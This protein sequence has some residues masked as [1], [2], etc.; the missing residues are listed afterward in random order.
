MKY[1]NIKRRL[2]T[3]SSVVGVT[4]LVLLIVLYSII[5]WHDSATKE[6]ETLQTQLAAVTNERQTLEG[7][8]H[9]IQQ[10]MDLYRDLMEK[11]ENDGLLVDRQALRVK[12]EDFKT[13][14]FL[15]GLSITMG[16]IKD[17]PDPKYRYKSS[18]MISSELTVDFDTLTDEDMFSFLN[19]L[20]NEL[21]GG[22]RVSQF[23]IERVSK[24]NDEALRAIAKTGQFSMV[25][26]QAKFTWM[27]IRAIE[28]D[29]AP[30]GAGAPR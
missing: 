22:L 1:E 27:G 11:S 20:E 13:R 16:A 30:G 4:L 3:E 8:Y 18:Q 12:I 7:K 25:K 23:N 10:N 29:E 21:A 19:A 5:A 15:N 9:K 2:I 28:E 17:M 26:G 24:V 6:K 14:Y